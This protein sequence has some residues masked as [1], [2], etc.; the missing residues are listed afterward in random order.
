MS[1]NRSNGSHSPF[2]PTRLSPPGFDPSAEYDRDP[3]LA[4]EQEADAEAEAYI[5][6]N[7]GDSGV[8]L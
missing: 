8:L 4:Y 5:A 6:R 1:D 2:R 3:A 7:Y